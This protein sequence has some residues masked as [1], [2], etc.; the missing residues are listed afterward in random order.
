MQNYS[1]YRNDHPPVAAIQ[2]NVGGGVASAVR[3]DI[4]HNQVTES[5]PEV[6]EVMEA[7][8]IEVCGIQICC[9]YFPGT[10]LYISISCNHFKLTLLK[11]RLFTKVN[12]WWRPQF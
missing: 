3:N 1:L 8:G 4:P 10:K 9:A 5:R 7:V 6:M 12:S 2:Q 11:Y